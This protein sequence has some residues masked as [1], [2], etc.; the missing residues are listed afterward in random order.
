L[1]EDY[2]QYIENFDTGGVDGFI[3]IFSP[4]REA[5]NV[6]LLQQI[7]KKLDGLRALKHET[8]PFPLF[9]QIGGLLPFGATDNANILY[10]L[11]RGNPEDWSIVI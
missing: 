4:L 7:P 8:I 2:K 9:P 11:V 6:N 5:P 3:W 1:P 10:W